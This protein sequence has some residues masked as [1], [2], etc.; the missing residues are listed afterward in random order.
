MRSGSASSASR[1]RKSSAVSSSSSARRRKQK[2][3]AAFCASSPPRSG[4]LSPFPAHDEEAELSAF[5]A[6]TEDE[7][8][9]PE[10][11]SIETLN[12]N[13]YY[14]RRDHKEKNYEGV[15][16][17]YVKAVEEK[18]LADSEMARKLKHHKLSAE[19]E[20]TFVERHY[21][22]SVADQEEMR[23]ALLKKLEEDRHVASGGSPTRQITRD[24]VDALV[25]RLY[26]KGN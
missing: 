13:L 14:N 10:P 23:A 4:A 22:K 20:G 6:T 3:K 11:P 17:K 15:F 2:E 1:R 18:R 25:S 9:A 7:D 12:K 5:A 19:E 21:K 24:Q 26:T 16:D 8:E